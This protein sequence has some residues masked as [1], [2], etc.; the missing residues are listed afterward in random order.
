[1]FASAIH[2]LVLG[3]ALFAAT[4][5]VVE[6]V[7]D[8]EYYR[9]GMGNPNVD[10][11]MY[12]ADAHNV[13]E[14]LDQFSSLYIQYHNCAWSQNRNQ[15]TEDEESGSGDETD[16]WYID[17]TPQ[18]TA[19]VAYSLYGSLTGESFSGCNGDTFINSFTTNSGFESF[20]SAIYYAGSSST[21]YSGTYSSECQGGAG[22]ACDYQVG[23]ATVSYS[24]NACDPYYST[25]VTD[26]MGYMNS[27]F[28]SAQCVKIFSG[29][30]NNYNNNNNN[31]NN[32]NNGNNRDLKQQQD[33]EGNSEGSKNYNNYG[34]GSNKEGGSEKNNEEDRN[35]QNN[36]G[37]GGYGYG[38]GYNSYSNYYNYAGT[39]LSVLYYSN[40]CFVQNFWAPNGGCPD[41]FGR[42]QLYQQNFNKG[43][44]KSMKVDTY[45]TYRANM[46]IGK[47]YVK[48]GALFF[49][50]AALLFVF[51]Q[52]MAFRSRKEDKRLGIKNKSKHKK[53]QVADGRDEK[54]PKKR[55]VV[56]LVRS[57]TGKLRDAANKTVA[58]ATKN[59][60]SGEEDDSD[61]KDGVMI[62]I[63]DDDN[64]DDDDIKA[65]SKSKKGTTSKESSYKAPSTSSSVKEVSSE[66]SIVKVEMPATEKR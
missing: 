47:K 51:E 35:L 50:A 57:A 49:M 56:G 42:L 11:K 6:A 40:A 65:S 34:D 41:P 16:Y 28:Q 9:A 60:C 66:D 36:Y 64:D 33:K 20:A 7:K 44:R 32:Y 31:N 2:A 46:E 26:S 55:S 53:G 18:Y 12:W 17:A 38:N 13:L 14:D 5:D 62:M 22:V 37:Y 19:N 61:E 54:N 25:G 21:D 30:S 4:V 8:D 15:Y 59:K 29:N 45:V 52:L 10:L 58:R 23:F 24:T 48:T 3:G 43:V 1:M 39:A 27:A 63:F